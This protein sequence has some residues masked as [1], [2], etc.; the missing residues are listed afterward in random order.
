ML[1]LCL[2]GG[3]STTGEETDRLLG[4]LLTLLAFS[5][6]ADQ[7]CLSRMQ[8]HVILSI[9]HPDEHGDVEFGYFLRVCCTVIPWTL[10]TLESRWS[11]VSELGDESLEP[12]LH[13][14]MFANFY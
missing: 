10:G 14:H 13:A 3:T 6:E 1:R 7:L 11:S 12:L 2:T 4:H 9:V 8:I 5:T